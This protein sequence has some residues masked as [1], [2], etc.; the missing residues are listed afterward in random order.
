MDGSMYRE[1]LEKNLRNLQH[2]LDMQQNIKLMYPI[3]LHR[4]ILNFDKKNG[5]NHDF[6]KFSFHIQLKQLYEI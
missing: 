1:I 2:L 6:L 4:V 5:F 3:L